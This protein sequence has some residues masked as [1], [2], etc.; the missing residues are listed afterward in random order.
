MPSVN[1]HKWGPS[2]EGPQTQTANKR[3]DVRRETLVS[4]QKPDQAEVLSVRIKGIQAGFTLIELMIVVAIIG[5][6]AAI[7]LPAYQDYTIRAHVTEPIVAMSTAKVDIHEEYHAL[8]SM[9][10][11]A[12]QI[13]AN[14]QTK[15][16]TSNYVNAA[17]Y[18]LTNADSATWTLTL[19]NLGSDADG[20]TLVIT[21]T[22]SA[23]GVT[24]ICS[25]G[26]LDAKYRP[27]ECRP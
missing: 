14:Q 21:F 10:P 12:S 23:G 20:D 7:A 13:I 25:G 5:I 4:T 26:T 16:L 24:V 17:V 8:G 9:P 22:G 6:L 27:A 15:F 19:Q 1:E 18:A 2:N 3:K 11:A